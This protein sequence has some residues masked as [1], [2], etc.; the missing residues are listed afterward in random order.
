MPVRNFR[1][2][3]ANISHFTPPGTLHDPSETGCE[4]LGKIAFKITTPVRR[5]AC[6]FPEPDPKEFHKGPEEFHQGP[7]GPPGGGGGTEPDEGEGG[8]GGPGAL[9]MLNIVLNSHASAQ[10][11]TPLEK[12]LRFQK[13]ALSNE[14]LV[15][16]RRTLSKNYTFQRASRLRETHIFKIKCRLVYAIRYFF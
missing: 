9:R 3:F 11:L 8:G 6:L 5:I 16:A 2:P 4:G 15:Y 10:L 1:H 7:R 13:N 14:R 12:S